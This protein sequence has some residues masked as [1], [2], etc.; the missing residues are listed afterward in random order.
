MSEPACAACCQFILPAQCVKLNFQRKDWDVLWNVKSTQT[1]PLGTEDPFIWIPEKT[2]SRVSCVTAKPVKT[3]C[4]FSFPLTRTHSLRHFRVTRSLKIP[5]GLVF[6]FLAVVDMNLAQCGM[7]GK[8]KYIQHTEWC[9]VYECWCSSRI[10]GRQKKAHWAG[11]LKIIQIR[12]LEISSSVYYCTWKKKT[13]FL[14]FSF[15]FLFYSL[16][17]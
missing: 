17:P 8:I 1:S 6:F 16:S 15:S 3:T 11:K 4:S 7:Y 5:V 12:W 14:F 9:D 2:A 13:A 10:C